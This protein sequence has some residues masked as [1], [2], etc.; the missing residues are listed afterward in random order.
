MASRTELRRQPSVQSELADMHLNAIENFR[1]EHKR[2]W[3]TRPFR[4]KGKTYEQYL[5]GKCRGMPAEV[6]KTVTD[7][8]FDKGKATSNRYRTRT[9]TVVAMREQLQDRFV[10]PDFTEVKRH[11]VRFWKNPKPQEHLL[12]TVLIRGAETK[13][14][15]D[16]QDCLTTF[17]PTSNPWLR[18]DNDDRR[19]RTREERERR[20]ARRQKRRTLSPSFRAPS[21]S[22][23]Y[24]DRSLSRR[25]RTRSVSP[26]SYRS[27]QNRDDSPPPLVRYSRSDS[28]PPYRSSSPRASPLPSRSPSVRIRVVPRY[29]PTHFDDAPFPPTPPESYTPPPDVSAYHRP[30]MFATPPPPP[31]PAPYPTGPATGSPF[32]PRPPM[33][34]YPMLTSGLPASRATDPPTPPHCLNCRATGTPPCVHHP[35]ALPCRRPV[36]WYAG[37]SYHPPCVAC[38][39]R[40]APP[41]AA[42]YFSPHHHHHTNNTNIVYG[43]Q[44]SFRGSRPSSSDN[45]P[46]PAA[47]CPPPIFNNTF[48]PF[49]IPPP[50][51]PP[52][53]RMTMPPMPMTMPPMP[54]MPPMPMPPPLPS[55]GSRPASWFADSPGPMPAAPNPF[56]PLSTPPLTSAGASSVGGSS[57]VLSSRA[58]TPVL[59]GGEEEVVQVVRGGVAVVGE[60][61]DGEGVGG[62]LE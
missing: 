6:R 16:G 45:F 18:C 51:P 41:G 57:P 17:S 5:D 56:S 9:W 55:T 26:P 30:G 40:P 21:P 48:A 47:A 31:F 3:A 61:V 8:L 36:A 37:V 27:R 19:R 2:S 1:A 11:K 34:V 46:L 59:E 25:A 33:P 13:V 53:A 44:G 15:P 49:C 7:L 39:T 42:T 43:S 50:P 35:R 52:P 54:S 58:R 60:G 38:A 29:T 24:R 23:S 32:Q 20:A 10:E 22:S 12:Y 14:V 4:G 28:P 62:G